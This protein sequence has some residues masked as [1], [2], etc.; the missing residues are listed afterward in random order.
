MLI[1]ILLFAAGLAGLYFGAEWLVGGAVRL[2]T[3]FGVS[4][5]I[6]GL[7]LV[8]FGTSAPELVVSG[9]ASYGG[10]GGL[11]IGNVLGSNVAN[12]ALILGVSALIVA[13]RVHRALLARD[14][15]IMIATAVLVLVLGWSGEISRIDGVILLVTFVA[16][17]GALAVVARRESAAPIP[18]AE[19][20][21][22]GLAEESSSPG[23]DIALALVGLIVLA[24]GAQALVTAAV[25][26]ATV[27]NVPEVVIGLTLVAFGTSLPELAAS[28][29]AARRGEGDIVIGNIIGSNI[30]N[31]TLILGVSAVIRPLPVSGQVLAVDAPLV[32]AL[33]IALLPIV[34]SKMKV[35]RWEGALLVTS[36]VG[37]VLWTAM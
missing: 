25:N 2:A 9:I 12:V 15:P 29:S 24:G 21:R 36:Y 22:E 3:A 27:L 31:V 17:T 34:W 7:T 32:I 30:F 26:I 19:L 28:I 37:F 10:N 6:V 20:E 18:L 1:D 4:S 33:S 5:F 13:I 23:K 16:Y 35:E 14:L 11:A 8:S